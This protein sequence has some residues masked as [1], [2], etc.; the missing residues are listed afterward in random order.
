MKWKGI[1]IKK[2]REK[3]LHK[4]RSS[5]GKFIRYLMLEAEITFLC[6]GIFRIEIDAIAKTSILD[7][8]QFEAEI[9][10]ILVKKEKR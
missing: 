2:E 10:K 4:S 6:L 7:K 8:D 1:G 5:D 3:E 9:K